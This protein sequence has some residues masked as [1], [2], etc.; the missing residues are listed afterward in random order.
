MQVE[1]YITIK[2]KG[3]QS[4]DV[5]YRRYGNKLLGYAMSNWKVDEDTAW[6]LIY[7]TLDSIIEHIDRYEFENED[8]F[9][10]F[11]LRAFL[12]NLRNHFRNQKKKV[13]L[14]SSEKMDFEDSIEEIQTDDSSKMKALKLELEK[15]E[16]WERMLLLLRAQQMPYSEIARYVKKPQNQLKVYYSRLKQKITKSLIQKE[17]VSH[18]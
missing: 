18:A 6:D 13:Q 8:K 1:T 16:D 9:S 11:V 7:K 3:K 15:L 2:E 10:S 12:N 4:V 14:V 5:F 17:E